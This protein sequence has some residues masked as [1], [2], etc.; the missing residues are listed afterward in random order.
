M[1][2]ILCVLFTLLLCVPTLALAQQTDASAQPR[3]VIT[4]LYDGEFEQVFDQS[5][6]DVQTALGGSAA[7][8]QGIWAQIEQLYGAFEGI[9]DVTVTTQSGYTVAQ[10]TCSHE[11]ADIT[12]TVALDADGLLSGLTVS[13]ITQKAAASTA[14]TSLFVTEEITLRAGEADETQGMLT[15]PVGDGPFPTVIMM[16]GSGS[17]GMDETAFGIAI[18]RDL[19]EGLAQAGVASIRY[20][21][22]N[23]AHAGLLTNDYTVQQ[24]YMV[25]AVDALA[26][27]QADDRI[28]DIYLLGH[29]LGGM[30]VPRVMQTLG[31]DNFA[32]GVILEGTPLQLWEIQ[33]HQNLALLDDLDESD[34]AVAQASV[35]AELAKLDTMPSMTAEEL[36][37]SLFFGISA[38]YQ[39]DLMSVDT[40][41][42]AIALQKPL[43]ITQGEKDWQIT[44][45]DGIDAWKAALGDQLT[46]VTYADYPNM[47]HML[48]DMEGESAGDTSDYT[49]G[50]TV[51]ETL[52]QDIAAWITAQ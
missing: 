31:A 7:G 51:S 5:T 34:R 45:A 41:Q 23:Y 32:G 10:I 49:S 12:Y 3:A 52:I 37:N 33:Y 13:G 2:R 27:L 40:A 20:D 43:F 14:D 36:Q 35:D 38:W 28:G 50:G 17:S 11:T 39:M 8:L 48:C 9:T 30:L 1:K 6:A 16:Q 26:L 21:K 24:E 4:L 42:T 47:N 46:T 19:A 22:Y 29:S 44:P 15:L 18:F 25:D